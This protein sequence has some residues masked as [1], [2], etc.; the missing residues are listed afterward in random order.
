MF[1]D[2]QLIVFHDFFFISYS[3]DTR[4]LKDK[5]YDTLPKSMTETKLLVKAREEDP[6]TQKQR[7]ELTRSKSPVELSQMSSISEFPIPTT[8]EKMLQKTRLAKDYNKIR[9]I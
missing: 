9:R 4:P 5:M 1:C 7:Q 6:E 8:I 3:E 2:I